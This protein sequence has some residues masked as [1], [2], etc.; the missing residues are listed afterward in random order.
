MTLNK[1]GMDNHECMDKNVFFIAAEEDRMK[2]LIPV[3]LLNS[4]LMNE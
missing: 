3:I 1:L 4:L 2:Q